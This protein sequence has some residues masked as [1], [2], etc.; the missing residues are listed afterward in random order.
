MTDS[1]KEEF[2]PGIHSDKNESEFLLTQILV[3]PRKSAANNWCGGNRRRT[4]FRRRWLQ[5]PT[6]LHR[7]VAA[8]D[9]THGG[10]G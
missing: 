5:T 6:H 4:N 1:V 7:G 3:S 8:E 10:E 9:Q 2:R